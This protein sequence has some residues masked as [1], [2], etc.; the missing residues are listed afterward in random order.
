MNARSFEGHIANIKLAVD[1]KVVADFVDKLALIEVAKYEGAH[2]VTLDEGTREAAT[3]AA[4]SAMWSII[5]S[6][7]EQR[8]EIW[9]K[10]SDV[11]DSAYKEHI[12]QSAG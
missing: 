10:L 2:G 9:Q 3:E 5:D 11:A 8:M 7:R 12:K 6:L 1:F 4:K